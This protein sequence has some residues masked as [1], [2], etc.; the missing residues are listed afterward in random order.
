MEAILSKFYYCENYQ[1]YNFIL[2]VNKTGEYGNTF[3]D[4]ETSVMKGII[5]IQSKVKANFVLMTGLYFVKTSW[6]SN[7]N[8]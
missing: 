7:N 4:F 8:N 5:L 6:C 1:Y 3:L 2:I